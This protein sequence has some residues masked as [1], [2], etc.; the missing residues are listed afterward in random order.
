MT[1][2]ADATLIQHVRVFD[3]DQIT[4][5]NSV[6]LRGE[7]IAEIGTDL[8]PLP[9]EA[10]VDGTGATALPGLIDAHTHVFAGSLEQALA[11]GVTTELDMFAEPRLVNALKQDAATRHDRAD[12]RSAG[13][14]ATVSGGH[15]TQLVDRGIY[16]PFPTI[17][18]S[19]DLDAFVAAR[20]AEGSDYLKIFID[21]GT[22]VGYPH[23]TL[24]SAAVAALVTAAHKRGLIT[25]AHPGSHAEVGWIVTDT[26]IDAL[27]HL[28]TDHT[29]SNELADRIADHGIFVIPTLG[30]SNAVCGRG[31]GPTLANDPLTGPFLDATSRMML[32]M[33]D[34]NF[35]LGPDAHTDPSAATGSIPLLLERGVTLLAGTDAGTV[36]VAHGASLHRELALLVD[37][38]LTASQALT[39][40]T[41]GPADAFT[42]ADR[43]RI[44]P[45]LLADILLVE[46]DPTIDITTTRRIRH[47]WHRGTPVNRH[48]FSTSC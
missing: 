11:F 18:T 22:V 41:A 42:L 25:L 23:P 20:A 15:P 12:L 7:L 2:A 48:R 47:I 30:V 4:D 5:A 32:T 34:G 45:G 13:T 38:G 27:A 37:A 28:P 19:T 33:M 1:A 40:A 24:D 16:P 14:G 21:D 10:I 35:P 39:A 46:G 29:L 6:R 44:Q 9:D 3:G 31:D 43:G 26:G 36:G 8:T 17:T